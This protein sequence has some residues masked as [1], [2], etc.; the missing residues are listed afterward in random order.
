M[1]NLDPLFFQF[2]EQFLKGPNVEQPKPPAAEHPVF[3]PVIYSY[4]RAQAIEDGV[5]INLGMF[6]DRGRPVLELVGIRFPVAMTSTAY[7][8]VMGEGEGPELLDTDVITR[9]VLYFL[10]VLKRAVLAHKGEDP[11][12]IEFT[13]TNSELQPIAL[14]AVCGPGDNAEPVI[15]VMLPM[16]D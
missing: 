1:S 7:S 11:T 2:F 15:T 9:R 6:V 10:A 5:L 4:T 13:C 3:G 12:I 8:L 14:K 16:E